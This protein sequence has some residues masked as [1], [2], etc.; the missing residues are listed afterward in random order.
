MTDQLHVEHRNETGT[1]RMR[2]LRKAGK[3]PAVLYGH[4]QDTVHLQI[5]ARDID[6][7]IRHGSHFVEL[8]GDVKD[9]A[10]ISEIQWDALGSEILHLDLTRVSAGETV[11]VSIPVELVGVAPGTRQ[12]GVLIQHLH[13]LEVHCPA[14]VL[15]EKLEV[16][17]NHLELDGVITVAEVPL[18][19][20]ASV[21]LPGDEV[22]VQ[23]SEPLA[24]PDEDEEAVGGA[25]EPEVIG[26]A[27]DESE[28]GDND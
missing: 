3:I 23:C 15:P 20:G 9:S 17:I 28:E 21:T 16:K 22:V 25:A 12:G 26:R 6:A 1:L 27:Q 5:S 13:E 2:R 24:V 11:E 19:E 4:G 18:P 7:A 14:R 8:D 10:L